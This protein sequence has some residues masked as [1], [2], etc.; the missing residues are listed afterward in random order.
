LIAGL[1]LLTLIVTACG[2]KNSNKRSAFPTRI[3]PTPTPRSTPLPEV[4][5]AP[6]LGQGDRQIVIQLALDGDKPDADAKQIAAELQSQ[7]TSDLDLEVSVEFVTE[8]EA[9]KTLCSG[10]PKAAWVNAFTYGV[11]QLRCEITPTLAIKRGRTPRVSVGTTAEIVAQSDFTALRQI[12]DQTFCRSA[13]QDEFTSWIFPSLLLSSQG[14]NPM[15]DIQVKDYPDDLALARA[16]YYKQCAAAGLPA[17]ELEDL[18]IDLAG[19][20]S[21]DANPVTSSDLAKAIKVIVPAGNTSAPAAS[22][23]WAG[24]GANV[25]PYE[26]LVFPPDSAIPEALRL[27]IVKTITDFFEDRADGSQRL[28]TL[29]DA[30]TGIVPVDANDY[31][32]FRAM[33]SSAKW[34]MTFED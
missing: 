2:G 14:V 31:T 23:S 30:A 28:S 6:E 11:A 1:I 26:V 17:D 12:H 5:P 19:D 18:L 7:L 33:I 25:I 24:F 3:P 9:L 16:L 21:T 27:E 20:I 8:N 15:L 22:G 29:L 34:N 10:A 13:E 4:S 32:A